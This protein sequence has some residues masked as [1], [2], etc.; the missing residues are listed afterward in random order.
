MEHYRALTDGLATGLGFVGV[1]GFA[2]DSSKWLVLLT[3]NVIAVMI[4]VAGRNVF[5]DE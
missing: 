3:M 5:K 4:A 1:F 2:I